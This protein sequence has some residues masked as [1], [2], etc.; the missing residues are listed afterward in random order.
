MSSGE[1]TDG[2]TQKVMTFLSYRPVQ[3]VLHT[4]VTTLPP[5]PPSAFPSDRLSSVLVSSAAKKYLDFH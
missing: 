5:S 3:P 4:T 2:V 1:V